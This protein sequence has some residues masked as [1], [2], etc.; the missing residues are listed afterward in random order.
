MNMADSLEA[1]EATF[2]TLR[3]ALLLGRFYYTGA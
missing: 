1:T 3:R 2:T